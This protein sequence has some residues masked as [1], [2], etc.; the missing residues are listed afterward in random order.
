MEKEQKLA[1]KAKATKSALNKSIH[2]ISAWPHTK[3]T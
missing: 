2:L 1:Q 3:S